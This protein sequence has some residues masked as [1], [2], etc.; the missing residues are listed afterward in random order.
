MT[1]CHDSMTAT[2]FGFEP[3]VNRGGYVSIPSGKQNA[4]ADGAPAWVPR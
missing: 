3:P 2:I 4:N 1:A